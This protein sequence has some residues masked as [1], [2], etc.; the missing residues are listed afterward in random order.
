MAKAPEVVPFVRPSQ[1]DEIADT[2]EKL[3]AR[4]RG[5]EFDAVVALAF[6]PDG[7]Y[8]TVE[9]GKRHSRLEMIGILEGLKIDLLK[10]TETDEPSG[11]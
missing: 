4:A 8:L 5:G 10:T 1:S 7:R 2:L 6:T 11:L 9:R 3:A